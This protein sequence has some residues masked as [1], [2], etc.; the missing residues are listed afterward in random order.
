MHD[1]APYVLASMLVTAVFIGIKLTAVRAVAS[2][3]RAAYMR[4]LRATYYHVFL[5]QIVSST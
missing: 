2:H 1:R 5:V 4:Q 3:L